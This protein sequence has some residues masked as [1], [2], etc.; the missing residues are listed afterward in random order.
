MSD[1]DLEQAFGLEQSMTVKIE[2]LVG[3][4]PQTFQYGN[5]FA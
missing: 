4:I 2:A 5:V 1:T 3:E